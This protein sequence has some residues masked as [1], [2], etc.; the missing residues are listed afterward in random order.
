VAGSRGQ[1]EPVSPERIA[2]MVTYR[3]MFDFVI[4]GNISAIRHAL[5]GGFN[6]NEP[7][8]YGFL[9]IHRACANHK[10]E[11]VSLLI[12]RGSKLDETATDK[13]TPLHLASIS[14]AA[15]CPT[16]LIKAGAQPDVQDKNGQTPL[17]LSVIS[18]SPELAIE[19][20]ALGSSKDIKNN[21]GLTPL[22]FAKEKN[23]SAFYKVLS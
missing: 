13:W 12:Q 14:G 16:I 21:N 4:E 3:D 18:R 22:E 23:A 7:D 20:I 19:L 17:H 11:I 10:P 9:L 5:D 6:V 2:M 8:E 1:D 15:G